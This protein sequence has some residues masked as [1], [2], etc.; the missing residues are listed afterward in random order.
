LHVAP[1]VSVA[2]GCPG[3]DNTATRCHPH[4]QPR[5]R[6][7]RR[8]PRLRQ[9]PAAADPQAHRP[10][11][12][13]RA[14]GDPLD[15][16]LGRRGPAGLVPH[17][18]ERTGVVDQGGQ[19]TQLP[20]LQGRADRA[21]RQRARTAARGAPR[22][23]PDGGAAARREPVAA[24]SVPAL[25]VTGMGSWPRPRW[26]VE[27]MHAHVQG[28]L[29][30]KAFQETA[31]DAVRLIASAQQR[32]GATVYTD[33][34]QRRDS[35]A[36]F[37][38][39]RLDNCQLVPLIDL[40]PLVED[41]AAFEAELRALDV[42]AGEVRH[43]GVFGRIR[44]SRPIAVHEFDFL[45]TLT[46]API[47]VACRALPADAH[48][49]DGL[50]RRQRVRHA[51][52]DRRRHRARAA[53][54]SWRTCWTPACR[55]CSWTNRCCPRWC[56][57]APRTSA[58]SCAA[59]CRSRRA[60]DQRHHAARWRADRRRGL[61]RR[62]EAGHRACA[63]RAG[64]PEMEVGI[65]VMGAHEVDLIR[66]I[67]Q[68][69]CARTHHGLGA[70]W[71]N[72]DLAAALRCQAD[73]VHLADQRVRHPDRT[74]A[75][76]EPRLGARHRSPLRRARRATPAP[77][78]AS[79]SRTRRAPTRL[80]G[81]GRAGRAGAGAVRVRYADTLGLLDPFGTFE[82]I[83]ALRREVDIDIEMHAHDDLGLATANTLAALRAGA[84]HAS[85]TVNG[86]GER[87]G[88]AALEEVV[89][90][91]RHLHG[92]E[93]GIDTTRCRPSRA[94]GA[95]LGPPGGG[96]QEHRR[97]RGVH[98]R[99]GHPC[100]RPAEGPPQLRSLPARGARPQHRLVLGKHSGS[101]GVRAA[102]A[103]LGL[104][105]DEPQ[106]QAL[107]ERIREHVATAPSTPATPTCC[108][109]TQTCC[110]SRRGWPAAGLTHPLRRPRHGPDHPL[111]ALSSAEDFLEFFAVPFDERGGACEPAAHP[112]ALLPVP[113]PAT[114]LAGWASELFR[115]YRELLARPT[116]TSCARR[117]RRRRSS[118]CS[119][120]PTARSTCSL[121]SLARAAA[122]RA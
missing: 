4:A 59:R 73:I 75:G 40:L 10:A 115:R 69:R 19:A 49:V 1:A 87:A 25:A 38:A 91:A 2:P 37:V 76:Q 60:R 13:G 30:D 111:K 90:A 79:A 74:Q 35:Y 26:L 77:R 104:V 29:D 99:V 5:R 108:A 54:G 45:R 100:R 53:R 116:R 52:A 47:K 42:P 16:D 7:R 24:P 109:S 86:L 41:P 98:A 3:L 18:E 78:S 46:P 68:A 33:G 85:T 50:H 120:T 9:W 71:P 118:R 97:R 23:R 21:H 117:R 112:Q 94:R 34:E 31:D 88:N 72:A 106:V 89:M 61:Q 110:Q 114:D 103:R 83:A 84:T 8:R 93:C 102:Y 14:A 22:R 44:R 32:A 43:P 56:S 92:L 82:R 15:R 66:A 64:V 105:L 119:R 113:A 122:P 20:G 28:R 101:H 55:W 48:D 17:D 121:D 62:R 6:L 95:G 27:A 107:L 11:A 67:T 12:A 63:R 57:A 58:A 96:G 51:R 36:S 65:P 81:A 70:A 39:T 80:P